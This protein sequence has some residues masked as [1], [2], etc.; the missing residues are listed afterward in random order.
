MTLAVVVLAAGQ[1]VRM[2]SKKQKILHAVGGQ[3]MVQHAFAAAAAVADLPPVVVIAPEEPGVPQLLGDQAVYV[4]Q[5]ERLGTGHAVQMAAPVL[6]GQA[7]Q[8]L[9]T[10][11]DMP[12]LTPAT[13][14]QLARLQA[15][16]GAVI[17]LLT[18][19]GQPE[20]TFGRIV[21]RADGT[22]A[23]IVETAEARRRPNGGELLAIPEHN[24]GV[25]C[26]NAAW[27]WANI[28]HLPLR[29]ARSGPEYYL[30]D[31]V[32]MAVAQEQQVQ[33]IV[34]TDPD[35]CL[36]AGTR[37]ELAAAEK[38]LQRRVNNRWLAAGVTLIDPERTCIET[39]VVIGPDTII[40]PG[41]YLQGRTVVGA[42]CVIGPNVILRQATVGDGCHIEQAVIERVSVPAQQR[43]GPFVHLRG[44]AE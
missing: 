29:Q 7:D 10:Y 25:Y 26:F 37:A 42:D 19:M 39:D 4:Y 5:V 28:V 32:G 22:V 6:T 21:R 33:A 38:A 11:A 1:G 30:T 34:A 35:E 16:S 23:E 27:L 20:S 43:V 9:V 24:A 18:V 3:P 17:S 41:C 31:L 13:L 2:N 44:T 14:R 12:L 36:G 8:V 40:W 15:E